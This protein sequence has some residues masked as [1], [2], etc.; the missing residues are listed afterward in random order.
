MPSH[1]WGELPCS[2]QGNRFERRLRIFYSQQKRNQGKAPDWSVPVVAYLARRYLE[3]QQTTSHR[4]PLVELRFP[5]K[6]RLC[7]S[8]EVV[9]TRL[10]CGPR[11]RPE[12]DEVV[13][14]DPGDESRHGRDRPYD[15]CHQRRSAGR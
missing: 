6:R 2:I 8:I 11:V 12:L 1:S 7:C 4:D 13:H 9:E 10:R 14:K 15:S 5:Q 3:F